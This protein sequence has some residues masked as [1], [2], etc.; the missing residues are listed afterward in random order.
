MKYEAS[1]VAGNKTKIKIPFD[2][3]NN[4]TLKSLL[5]EIDRRSGND[6]SRQSFG[7]QSP[8]QHLHFKYKDLEDDGDIITIK[9]DGELLY[10][11]EQT[12]R[13]GLPT[14][15]LELVDENIF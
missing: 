14:A 11:I 2:D 9:T 1:F 15:N 5:S 7:P 6:A 8:Q 12:Q 13:L 3:A 4:I 10:V